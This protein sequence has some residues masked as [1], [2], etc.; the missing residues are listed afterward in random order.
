MC[1]SDG[2]AETLRAEREVI[3]AAGAFHSPQLLMLSGV[4]PPD[5]LRDHAIAVAHERPG[6]GGNLQDHLE[7]HMQW[8][9]DRRHTRNR[10]AGPLA[11]L[12]VGAQWFLTRRGVCASDAGRGR[13]RQGVLNALLSTGSVP[14]G[15]RAREFKKHWHFRRGVHEQGGTR[16][17]STDATQESV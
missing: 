3:L 2:S 12:V 1:S 6:V 7:V 9:A 4:G 14:M 15:L 5:H 17:Q 10:Y 13:Y 16:V 11:R 8:R